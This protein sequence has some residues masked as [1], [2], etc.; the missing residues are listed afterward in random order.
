MKFY[1]VNIRLI[2]SV[3]LLSALAAGFIVSGRYIAASSSPKEIPVYCVDTEKNEISITFDCA[4]SADDI[5]SV[6]ETLAKYNCPAT[7]FAVGDWVEKYPDAVKK[8]SENGHTVA[9]HSYS[10]AHF[11]NLTAQQ[12]LSDMDKCDS[13]IESVTGKRPVLFRAPY[14]EYNDTLIRQC[15]NTGRFYIQWSVD[16][17]DWT[18]ISADEIYNRVVQKTKPG[19]IILFHNG[20]KYTKDV[21]PRILEKLSEN[22][23]FTLTENMIYKD[24]YT[25]DHT[26]RQHKN[27]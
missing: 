2:L 27:K 18:D 20:T 14:G 16:S 7:F 12:M 17:L 19:D 15:G 6:I 13:L 3:I 1:V 8:L 26:G 25:I 22:Y 10:H 9:N 23:T 21:L 11:N 4:W 24:N 5:D